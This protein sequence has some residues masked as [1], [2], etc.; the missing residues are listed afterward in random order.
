MKVAKSK[1]AATILYN[2]IIKSDDYYEVG[3]RVIK[4]AM[5]R[6]IAGKTLKIPQPGDF[7]ND[8]DKYFT[9]LNKHM[10]EVEKLAKKQKKGK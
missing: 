6:R 1:R 8:M 9:A 5:S 4:E 2:K 3:M 10:K 7:G